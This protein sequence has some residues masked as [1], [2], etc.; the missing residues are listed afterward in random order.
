MAVDLG[1]LRPGTAYGGEQVVIYNGGMLNSVLRYRSKE[2]AK[3]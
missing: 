3:F 2:Y 1:V